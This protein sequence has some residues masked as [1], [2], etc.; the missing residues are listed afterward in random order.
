MWIG[1]TLALR[2]DTDD[3]TYASGASYAT[4]DA[5]WFSVALSYGLPLWRSR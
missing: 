1:A 3:L 5:P 2:H 4:G